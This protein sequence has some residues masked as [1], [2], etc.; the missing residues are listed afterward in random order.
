[1]PFAQPRDCD[2]DLEAIVADLAEVPKDLL[3]FN[4]KFFLQLDCRGHKIQG[5]RLSDTLIWRIYEIKTWKKNDKRNKIFAAQTF[6]RAT[7]G[8]GADIFSIVSPCC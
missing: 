7:R 6:L 2:G 4:V 3:T 5:Y 1:M 8:L